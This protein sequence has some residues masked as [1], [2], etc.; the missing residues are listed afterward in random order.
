MN[1]VADCQF[2]PQGPV[3]SAEDAYRREREA[4]DRMQK[5]IDRLN[6]V[7]STAVDRLAPLCN[8]INPSVLAVRDVVDSLRRGRTR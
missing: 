8:S 3:A 2:V 1:P 7:I 4:C 6:A 5:E